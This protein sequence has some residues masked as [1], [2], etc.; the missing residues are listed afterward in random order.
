LLPDMSG[1][2]VLRAVRAQ[3]VNAAVPV[4]VLTVVAED[5]TKG[6]VVHD[7]LPKPI[8]AASLLASLKA[9]G[10]RP[11]PNATVLVLDDDPLA[12]EL[13]TATLGHL[14]YRADC[15]QDGL[16]ALAAI[17]RGSPVAVVLD[18]LM[19]ELDGLEFL[20]RLRE[21]PQ[22]AALP[23]LVWTAMD[24]SGSELESLKPRVSA[25]ARKG[26]SSSE[27]VQALKACLSARSA[28]DRHG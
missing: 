19:P 24:L 27:V 21:S 10:V 2:D 22:S 23:V 8:D 20:A 17:S 9:A 12:L 28:E 14:G 26:G 5:V 1:F 15:H 4:V 13:M 11:E 18:L 3:G 25:I 7:V 16:K 6:Y